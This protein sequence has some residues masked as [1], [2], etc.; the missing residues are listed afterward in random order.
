MCLSV[1]YSP[2]PRYILYTYMYIFTQGKGGSGGK[3]NLREGWRGN[4]SQSWIKNTNITECISLYSPVFKLWYHLP[5]SPFTGKIFRWRP[6]WRIHD[7]LGWI[8]IPIQILGSMP[9]TN[10]SGFGS[11]SW[12]RILLFSS[13]T[14][15]MPAKNNFFLLITFW[16]YI[17]IIFQR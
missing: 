6:V 17:Y 12:L 16:S 1:W 11:G 8:R 4:S 3:L 13:L 5:Q 7:I 2:T 10:G 9:L 14:F 15:K